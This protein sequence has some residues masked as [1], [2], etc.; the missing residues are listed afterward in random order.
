V[1]AAAALEIV[2]RRARRGLAGRIQAACAEGARAAG[3]RA[4]ELMAT[5]PGDPS[6]RALGFVAV[7]RVETGR[8]GI[9][10]PTVRMRLAP[11]ASTSAG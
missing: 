5:L 4:L 3:F 10:V 11:D 8:P 9:V 7:E 2:L 1:V 6:Y